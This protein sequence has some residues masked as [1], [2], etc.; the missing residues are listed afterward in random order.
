MVLRRHLCSGLTF[1]LAFW[2]LGGLGVETAQ[3]YRLTHRDLRYYGFSGIYRGHAEGITSIWNGLD[4]DLYPVNEP[5]SETLPVAS[6]RVVTG[7]S[8]DNGFLLIHRPVNG[9]FRR[10]TIRAYY[11]G[12]SFNPQFGENMVG[13]GSKL[14]RVVRRGFSRPSLEMSVSDSL[15]ERSEFDGTLFTSWRLRGLY[16]K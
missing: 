7:P 3:A 13:S 6:R 1:V 14:I 5:S 8:G 12:T 4:Y 11:S 9:N 15:D 10:M 16:T 2:I